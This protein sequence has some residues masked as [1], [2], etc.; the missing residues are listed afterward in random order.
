MSFYDGADA[1]RR[2]IGRGFPSTVCPALRAGHPSDAAGHSSSQTSLLL[3]LPL[4][5]GRYENM[6]KEMNL[7]SEL[8]NS[9]DPADPNFRPTEIYNESWLI[10]LVMHYASS[11]KDPNFPINFH[12]GSTWYSEALLPTTF[13]ARYQGDKLSESRTNADGVIGHFQIG[14]QAKADFELSPTASQFIVLEAKMFSPLSPGITHAKY[15][16]QAARSVA[17]IAEAIS[18]SGVEHGQ[19]DDVGFFVLAP[20]ASIDKGTFDKQLSKSSIQEKVNKRVRAYGDKFKDWYE[21][22]FLPTLDEIH[23]NSFSW[24]YVLNWLS[25]NK[26]VIKKD[27]E[28]YYQQCLD[29]T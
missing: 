29:F 26:P 12:P 17:C 20:E 18:L 27:L 11:I 10:K 16:D 2:A 28:H 4:I 13:K 19:I 23:I 5:H 15:Y 9:F 21:I 1:S 22:C 8:I 3:P 24:E 6:E 14:N 7:V 25:T